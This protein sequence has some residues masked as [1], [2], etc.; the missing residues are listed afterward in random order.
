MNLEQL[1]EKLYDAATLAQADRMMSENDRK[2]G[3]VP[4]SRDV[5]CKFSDLFSPAKDH[6]FSMAQFVLDNFES[7][8]ISLPDSWRI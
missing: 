7:K 4:D 2:R 8:R 5:S 3:K 1:A 6:Y